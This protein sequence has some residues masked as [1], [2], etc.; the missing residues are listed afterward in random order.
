MQTQKRVYIELPFNGGNN[1]LTRHHRLTKKKSN[2]RN[3]VGH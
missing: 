2:A 1:A 3:G